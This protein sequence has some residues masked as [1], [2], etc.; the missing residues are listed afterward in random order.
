MLSCITFRLSADFSFVS[1]AH[2]NNQATYSRV[3]CWISRINFWYSKYEDRSCEESEF[4]GSCHR[5]GCAPGLSHSTYFLKFLHCWSDFLVQNLK[6]GK[7]RTRLSSHN[8]YVE[9][10]GGERAKCLIRCPSYCLNLL[11]L[12]FFFFNG[13]LSTDL[14]A[15]VHSGPRCFFNHGEDLE[16]RVRVK[17]PRNGRVLTDKCCALRA[18]CTSGGFMFRTLV[19][20]P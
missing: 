11:Q 10:K 3:R 9:V 14:L 13:L 19:I 2:T 6:K 20:L 8:S 7:K 17:P 16:Q 4:H 12:G 5:S 18:Q 15:L 1:S